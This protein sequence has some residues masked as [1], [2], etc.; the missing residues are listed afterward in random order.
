MPMFLWLPTE[1]AAFIRPIS[2]CRRIDRFAPNRSTKADAWLGQS[3]VIL[4]RIGLSRHV[5]FPPVSEHGANIAGCLKRA[6]S[7]NPRRPTTCGLA[8]A[9]R[10]APRA[11]WS[12]M[13]RQSLDAG[14]NAF[15]AAEE[16]VQ[17]YLYHSAG[18]S[19]TVKSAGSFVCTSPHASFNSFAWVKLASLRSA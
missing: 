6:T 8:S 18:H 1:S 11:S 10:R 7:G 2:Q 17:V 4:D 16:R 19:F 3:W 5:R 14:E 13:I 9:N 12:R 15:L